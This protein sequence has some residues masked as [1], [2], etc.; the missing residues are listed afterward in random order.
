[1]LTNLIA[2]ILGDYTKQF[3]IY[4]A[5][6]L[7]FLLCALPYGFR[8]RRRKGFPLRLFLGIV[9]CFAIYVGIAVVR[10][11]YNFMLTRILCS[12]FTY[13]AM[14]PMLFL[15]FQERISALLMCW[16]AVVATQEIGAKVFSLAL[17]LFHVD[18]RATISFFPDYVG[19][20]DWGI[21]YLLHIAVYAG[22][23]WA[24]GRTEQTEGDR[25]L[26][27]SITDISVAA[28]LTLSILGSFTA[29]F[30]GESRVLYI[31]LQVLTIQYA[32]SILVLR[33]GLLTQ[34]QYRQELA[35]MEQVIYEEKKQYDSVKES[36]DIINMKCHDLKHRLA[37][38][39]GK[40]TAQ[41]V[42][43]LQEAV[44]IYDS[45]IKTGSETLDVILYEKQLIAQQEG[46]R[47]S[48]LADGASL[49]FMSAAHLYSLF[50]NAI[51]NALEAVR[52]ISN[53]EKRIVSTTIRRTA[54]GV[55]ISVANYFQGEVRSVNGLPATTKED[56]N[57][58]GFGVKSMR[59]IVEQ[60]HGRLDTSVNGDMFELEICF[61]LQA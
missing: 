42:Q 58:H 51:S 25:Y 29:E 11:D 24:F 54:S 41:E 36:I 30:R 44:N 32:I 13:F 50:N 56:K 39:E 49:S 55:E 10:T 37:D 23:F 48:C 40:L 17:D 19:V 12:L 28:T 47:M 57:H 43:T 18:G 4:S 60:Y 5:S 15:C 31:I 45:S 53:P 38:F 26:T 14:L 46:V 16:C 6:F 1:M 21:Y 7:E 34:W 22:C 33:R 8:L 52:S 59:Y 3:I 35:L 61:P 20:R 2:S 9:C 27:R